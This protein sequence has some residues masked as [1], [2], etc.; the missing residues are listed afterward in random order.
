MHV[1]AR[2]GSEIS[3]SSIDASGDAAVRAEADRGRI[4]RAHL[5]ADQADLHVRADDSTINN[6]DLRSSGPRRIDGGGEQR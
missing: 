3:D 1:T 6:V 5:T 4:E 2:R